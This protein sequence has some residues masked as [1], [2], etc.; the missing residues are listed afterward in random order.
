M[1]NNIQQEQIL[2]NLQSASSEVRMKSIEQMMYLETL[3]V[4]EKRKYLT[5]AL[6]DQEEAIRG[7]AQS[8]LDYLQQIAPVAPNVEPQ[9]TE[10]VSIIEEPVQPPAEADDLFS[11]PEMGLID[12]PVSEPQATDIFA[13]PVSEP[14]TP[15][16]ATPLEQSIPGDPVD[17]TLPNLDAISNIPDFLQ[18]IRMLI[19]EKPS[20]TLTHL[21]KLAGHY[22]EEVALAALQGLLNVKDSRAANLILDYLADNKYSSQRRFLML[23]I[24]MDAESNLDSEKIEQIL[25]NEKDVIVKSGLVKVFARN[26][27]EIGVQTLIRCLEDDD[28]RVRANTVEVIEEQKILGCDEYIVKLLNDDENRVKVNAAKYLVK[29]GYHEAFK[30]LREMLVSSEVWLRDSVIFALGEIGDQASLTLLKAALKDP[31]QGIRLSVLKSLAK[32]NNNLARQVLQAAAGD[33]DPVVAQVA[34]SLWEKIKNQPVKEAVVLP[35]KPIVN[36]APASAQPATPVQP[37]AP[38]TPAQPVQPAQPVAPVTSAQPVQPAQP[39]APVTPAQPVQPA[40][41]VA[42][43]TPAQPVQPAQPV[44]PVTPAQPVQ[45]AQPVAPVT[46]AQPVQPAQPVAPATPVQ[47]AQPVAPV[48]PAQPVQPAQPVA[49]VTPVQPVQPAQPVAPATPVQPVQPAQPVAPVTPVQPVQPAQPVAPVTPVQ[50]A[51]PVAATG[52]N[53]QKQRSVDIYNRLKSP[54]PDDWKLALK[55][56]PFVMG[57]DQM[58]LLELAVTSPDDNVRLSAAKILARKRNAQ[59]RQLLEQLRND[60]SELVVSVVQKALLMLK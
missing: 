4:E 22:Q 48:T 15:E 25:I 58:I 32:I 11:L 24:V 56:L 49:P 3:P 39:V 9:P 51:Q 29:N 23:K 41:P 42:P 16:V 27:G 2:Q 18:H 20:G 35:T 21:I 28:P 59:G 54:N 33:P 45:P 40:Q 8:C 12:E 13:N 50:P 37:V 34:N 52:Y 10:P 17:P 5:N 36:A 30:T 19:E 1:G 6:S 47:P 46:P 7:Y 38:V 26:S 14:V 57:N 43:V 55:D 53:F 60:P 44:A 31:N